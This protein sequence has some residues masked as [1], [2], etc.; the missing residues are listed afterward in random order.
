MKARQTSPTKIIH[1]F[2]GLEIGRISLKFVLTDSVMSR[3]S[4]K[5]VIMVW[6]VGCLTALASAHRWLHGDK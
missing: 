2:L 6:L 1:E 4:Q 5:S 3:S